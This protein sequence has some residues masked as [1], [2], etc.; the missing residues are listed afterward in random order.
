MRFPMTTSTLSLLMLL[1]LHAAEAALSISSLSSLPSL[2]TEIQTP[3]Q[4]LLAYLSTTHD[5]SP[6]N[7]SA[8]CTT[9]L[10]R[11][12]TALFL[13]NARIPLSSAGFIGCFLEKPQGPQA[14]EDNQ[15]Q[16][17]V[18]TGIPAGWQFS[19]TE[20]TVGG[21]LDL[22]KGSFVERVSLSLIYPVATFTEKIAGGGDGD[23]SSTEH[24]M[25]NS[26]DE[27]VERDKGWK[28]DL[29]KRR[30]PGKTSKATPGT[31]SQSQA[32]VDIATALT[33]YGRFGTG[34]QGGF[35]LSIPVKPSSGASKKGK[36]KRRLAVSSCSTGT[37]MQVRLGAELWFS[38]SSEQIEFDDTVAHRG[39][40]GGEL[41]EPGELP[42]EG[43]GRHQGWEACEKTL[44]VGMRGEWKRC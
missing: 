40:L 18:F 43:D 12:K 4:N 38:L 34:Y 27:E 33:P 20:I 5:T 29:I 42:G 2:A 36:R 30:E 26:Q 37:E 11:D 31:K 13:P 39:M 3:N 21:W 44:R 6:L 35:N 1:Q 25:H 10:S 15:H 14:E 41:G 24:D 17:L 7:S 8:L 19:I 32:L 22:E 23:G 9:I 16:Q 28:W